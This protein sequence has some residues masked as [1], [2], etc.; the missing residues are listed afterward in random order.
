MADVLKYS[1]K[2]IVSDI[3]ASNIRFGLYLENADGQDATVEYI[4]KYDRST[5]GAFHDALTTYQRSL[6]RKIDISALPIS[7]AAAGSRINAH[8]WRF[9]QEQWAFKKDPRIISTISDLE[10][11]A[12]GALS[13]KTHVEIRAGASEKDPQMNDTV[14]AV[15]TGLGLSYVDRTGITQKTHGGHMCAFGITLEQNTILRIVQRLAD[16][17]YMVVYEDLASGLGL[18][19]L[20]QAVCLYNG[21]PVLFVTPEDILEKADANVL[22]Q[23]LRLFHE[24]LGLFAHMALVFGHGYHGLY[25]G[26]GVIDVLNKRG[27][28]DQETFIKFLNQDAQPIVAKNLENC[29]IYLISDS[30][31]ALYGAGQA[32][33]HLECA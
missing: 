24:F 12:L 20:Y 1:K 14:I 21:F 4:E 8:S 13:N 11:F 28:F 26:G 25:L 30:N 7:I 33:H 18:V 32:T 23:T 19:K 10:G 16:R 6:A 17:D 3:G 9:S 22:E 2:V 5:F 29:P 31:I 15:G 27:L